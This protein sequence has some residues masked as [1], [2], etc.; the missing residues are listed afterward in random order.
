MEDQGQVFADVDQL[1]EIFLVLP[2]VDYPAGVISEQPEVPIDVQIDRRRLYA[3]VV[4]GVNGNAPG[5]EG[6][7]DRTV[8]ENHAR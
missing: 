8:R 2:D 6:F 3:T 5:V 1:G 7:T 4:A